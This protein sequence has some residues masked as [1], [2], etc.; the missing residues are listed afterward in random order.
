MFYTGH[1]KY[2]D[3]SNTAYNDSF[4]WSSRTPYIDA[5]LI[6]LFDIYIWNESITE[7]RDY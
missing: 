6:I 5:L 1:L 4:S 2:M 7:A 3:I